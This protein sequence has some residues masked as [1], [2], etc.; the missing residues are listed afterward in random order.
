MI[1][2]ILL[3]SYVLFLFVC[4]CFANENAELDKEGRYLYTIQNIGVSYHSLYTI[5]LSKRY[6]RSFQKGRKICLQ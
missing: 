4:M 3:S 1:Q 5:K 2:C 6:N